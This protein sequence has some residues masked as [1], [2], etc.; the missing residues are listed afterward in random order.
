MPRLELD[1][2]H[3]PAVG[4]RARAS[5]KPRPPWR[6]LDIR[7]AS[8]VDDTAMLAEQDRAYEDVGGCTD[9]CGERANVGR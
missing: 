6:H 3:F 9:E 1:R 5:T 4:H 2:R 7:D 8:T